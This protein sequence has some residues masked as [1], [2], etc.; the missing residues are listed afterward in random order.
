MSVLE[1]FFCAGGGKVVTKRKIKKADPLCEL[2][3]FDA[4]GPMM[5]QEF[6]AVS[7]KDV[8]V[9]THL[10]LGSEALTMANILLV[11]AHSLLTIA[12]VPENLSGDLM[13]IMQQVNS[14]GKVRSAAENQKRLDRRDRGVSDDWPTDQSDSEVPF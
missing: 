8:E 14:V 5:N 13:S 12:E 1:R 7:E 6:L 10:G 11:G 4:E 2:L 3:V 9:R